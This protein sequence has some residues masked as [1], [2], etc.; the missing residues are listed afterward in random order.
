MDPVSDESGELPGPDGPQTSPTS[1]S[2]NAVLDNL[3]W[4][5]HAATFQDPVHHS[6]LTVDSHLSE[7]PSPLLQLDF[8]SG[9]VPAMTVATEGNILASSTLD[10]FFD[11][12]SALVP[13]ILPAPANL[14]AP[15]GVHEHG[16]SAST[17]A[18][19]D[20]FAPAPAPSSHSVPTV[21]EIREQQWS[22][23]DATAAVITDVAAAC[24]V[25]GPAW[26]LGGIEPP[27]GSVD[28]GSWTASGYNEEQQ[29]PLG[30]DSKGEIL[31]DT[32]NEN[33]P[34]A[35]ISPPPSVLQVFDQ[36]APVSTSSPDAFASD[37][38]TGFGSVDNFSSEDH[39]VHSEESEPTHPMQPEGRAASA[40][41][42]LE[43]PPAP[44]AF[45]AQDAFAADAGTDFAPT[46]EAADFGSADG[47]AAD[48]GSS[49]STSD[50]FGATSSGFGSADGFAIDSGS[51][52]GASDAFGA[53]TTAGF[54]GISSGFGSSDAFGTDSAAGFATADGFVD[55]SPAAPAVKPPIVPP[56]KLSFASAASSEDTPLRTRE[57]SGLPS[58]AN[59]STPTKAN[60]NDDFDSDSGDEAAKKPKFKFVIKSSSEISAAAAAAPASAPI[61]LA[62]TPAS[63]DS[64][65]SRGERSRRVVA[66]ESHDEPSA[67]APAAADRSPLAK[68][69]SVQ[70][71]AIDA[72]IKQYS[73]TQGISAAQVDVGEGHVEANQYREL[74]AQLIELKLSWA[75]VRTLFAPF[76][77][78]L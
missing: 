10:D 46:E 13:A 60:R 11:G 74:E 55:E 19:D 1:H 41:N 78:P 57:T 50:A 70:H 16:S 30:V 21:P 59:V 4:V 42:S 12:A 25:V 44:E 72:Q 62:M 28:M 69:S 65:G 24:G 37:S 76:L 64:T 51:A 39:A 33:H 7:A 27:Q 8:H 63:S 32:L 17:S 5:D 77:A 49:F 73:K 20:L 47:F 18:L 43:A 9:A 75:L 2:A 40:D 31:H 26:T 61:V 3:L 15:G 56:L 54:E 67:P 35:P 58:F 14:A 6:A 36:Q 71:T 48:F 34:P 66:D 68:R 52:F 53:D 23:E 29:M 45:S 38:A 22:E